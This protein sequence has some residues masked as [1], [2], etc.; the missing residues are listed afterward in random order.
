M[1][2]IVKNKNQRQSTETKNEKHFYKVEKS[3]NT[4]LNHPEPNPT[5][6][7]ST[8]PPNTQPNPT[9]NPT[10]NPPPSFLSVCFLEFLATLKTQH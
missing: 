9:P 10:P 4:I 5:T 3:H 2:L 8:Q 7:H 6:Q 1:I